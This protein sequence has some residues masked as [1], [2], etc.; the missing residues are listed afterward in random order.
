[1]CTYTKLLFRLFYTFYVLVIAQRR[2]AIRY[3]RIHMLVLQRYSAWERDYQKLAKRLMKESNDCII[4]LMKT[5][6]DQ[7]LDEEGERFFVHVQRE[8]EVSPVFLKT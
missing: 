3:A 5:E 8:Y 6:S 7:G 1:M 2:D 4:F